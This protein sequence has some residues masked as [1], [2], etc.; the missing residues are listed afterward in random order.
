MQDPSDSMEFTEREENG[1]GDSTDSPAGDD[2][3][4]GSGGDSTTASAVLAEIFPGVVAV[5]GE[6]T[7]DLKSELMLE[8]IDFGLVSATD[9]EQISTFLASIGNTATVGGNLANAFASLE[10]VYRVSGA[11]QALL[12]AGGTLAVKDGAY[13][14]AI[15]ANSKIAAQAR[16]IPLTQVSMAQ[17]LAAIGPAL[18]MAALQVQLSVITSLA[19]TN[20]ALT[21]QVLTTV[22]RAQW[23]ALSGLVETVDDAF[24]EAREVGSVTPH[25]WEPIAT[26]KA[27]LGTARDQYQSYVRG[28]VQKI[29]KLGAHDR[30]EYLEMNAETIVFDAYA[31]RSSLEALTKH[32]VLRAAKASAAGRED[33]DEARLVEVIARDA[34]EERDSALAEMTSLVYS[35]TR[36]LRI[37]A[38]LPG[39][40][41]MPLTRKRKDSKAARLTCA[42]LL[43]AIQ[44]LADALHPPVPPLETPDVVCGPDSLELEPYLRILRWFLEDGE[45]LR[46]LGFSDQLDVLGAFGVASGG[47]KEKVAATKEKAVAAIDKAAAKNMVAVTDRRIITAKISTFR[48][49]GQIGQEI[50]IEKVRYVRAPTRDG[51]GRSA[52]D[53]I[54][55]DENIR[56]IFHADIDN[57]KVDALAAILAE[58]MTIPDAERDQLHRHGHAAITAAEGADPWSS[59]AIESVAATGDTGQEPS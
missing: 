29:K 44:P 37:I 5:S 34:R 21:N 18:A 54:T 19:K 4:T 35:L 20:I 8:P 1:Q 10:G 7:E 25:V 2:L 16:F 58:S 33:A 30:R 52:I 53:I 47:A 48:K 41:T 22:T 59:T 11:T 9:R 3:T 31:L 50:P 15:F 17:S 12:N 13:L 45:S 38:Q 39:R 23:A 55:P 14:G 49:H 40:A 24:R 27:D 26:K 6:I 43:K 56:T 51:N 57:A 28:H 36:E 46:V 32:Q 42:Q